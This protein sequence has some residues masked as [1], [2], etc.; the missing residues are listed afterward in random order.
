MWLW[1]RKLTDP[2]STLF[3]NYKCLLSFHPHPCDQHSC[4]RCVS[5]NFYSLINLTC[6]TCKISWILPPPVHLLLPHFFS[7]LFPLSLPP[8]I[9]GCFGGV[10]TQTNNNDHASMSVSIPACLLLSCHSAGRQEMKS[11]LIGFPLLTKWGLWNTVFA[12]VY[13]VLRKI[14]IHSQPCYKISSIN[15]W[16]TWFLAYLTQL[17]GKQYINWVERLLVERF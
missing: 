2:A 10:S 3:V 8:S 5:S 7:L 15:V 9:F 11:M 16:I 14:D 6:Q 1:P 4:N 12:C 13:Y 17:E